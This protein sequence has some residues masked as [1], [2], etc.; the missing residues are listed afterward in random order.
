M[1]LDFIAFSVW[2]DYSLKTYDF[3]VCGHLMPK[4]SRNS[5]AVA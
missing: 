4:I 5:L 2:L 3:C 1:V